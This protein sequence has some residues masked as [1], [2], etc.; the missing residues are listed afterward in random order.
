M[1]PKKVHSFSALT[2]AGPCQKEK[3]KDLASILVVGFY[4]VAIA[5]S[6]FVNFFFLLP[7]NNLFVLFLSSLR[8]SDALQLSK[9]SLIKQGGA[10]FSAI[11]G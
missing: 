3:E 11:S 7:H 6:E 4:G 2:P 8:F 9:S 1:E 10:Y 5:S